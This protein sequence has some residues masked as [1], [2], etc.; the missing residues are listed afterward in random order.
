MN[1]KERLLAVSMFLDGVKKGT[2]QKLMH[3]SNKYMGTWI[4]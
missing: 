2:I 4:I 1:S 3:R